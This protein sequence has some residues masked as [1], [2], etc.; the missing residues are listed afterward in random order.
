MAKREHAW[1]GATPGTGVRYGRN[2]MVASASSRAAAAGMNVLQRGGNAFDAAIAVAGVEWL[3]LPA[4]CGLGGDMFAVLYDAKQDRVSAING[5][6]VAALGASREYYVDQGLEEMPGDGWHAVAVPGAPGA[7]AALNGEFGSMALG[8]LLAPAVSCAEEGILVSDKMSGMFAWASKT[9]EKYRYSAPLY[10]PGGS[11]PSPGDTWKLPDLACTIRTFCEEGADPFYTGEIAAEMVRACKEEDGLFGPEEF[12]EH[13]TE[14]YDPLH[15]TYRGVDVYTTAPPSQGVIVLEWLNLM[16]CYDLATHGFGSADAIH[17]MVETKKL[18]FADRLRYCGDPRFIDNPLDELLS[19]SYAERRRSGVDPGRANND[20]T[21]AALKEQGG[22]TSYF[23]VAD[24]DGN[25]ISMIH[26]LSAAFGCCV[27]AGETGVM[28]NNRAGRGFT[29]EERHPNVIAGG[30]KT[31]HTL[32]CYLL[33]KK[34]RPYAAVGTPGGD[35]QAQW[36]VQAIANLIDFGMD[37]QEAVEAPRWVSWPGTDPASIKTP[38]EI[39][40]EDRFDDEVIAE[41]E[42]RGHRV[43]PMGGWSGGGSL[44]IV[45][46]EEDGTLLGGCDPRSGGVALGF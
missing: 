3:T 34:G 16:E 12:A 7:Y 26:S 29:L 20:P 19:K 10:L 44:Q 36:D 39:R 23:A 21:P 14:V 27:V 46:R 22:N 33:C 15:T 9:L 38:L 30:K 13:T 32:N 37:V 5:S 35:R 17:L 18:A 1:Q 41:L 45:A 28:L 25:V 43:S 11:A 4:M 2:G 8:D 42:G 24:G 40:I 31:M 6:G